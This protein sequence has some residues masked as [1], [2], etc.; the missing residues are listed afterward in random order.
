[1]SS[2]KMFEID[3]TKLHQY[4]EVD[5]Y[6]CGNKGKFGLFIPKNS[7]MDLKSVNPQKKLYVNREDRI[8]LIKRWIRR[9][10]NNV[11]ISYDEDPKKAKGYLFKVA[12]HFFMDKDPSVVE[13]AKYFITA[14]A[15]MFEKYPDIMEK[16]SFISAKDYSIHYHNINVM[17]YCMDFATKNKRTREDVIVA[18]LTGFLHDIG[19]IDIDEAILMKKD[20]LTKEE[21]TLIQNHPRFGI[22]I[23][24][25]CKIDSRIIDVV[26]EHHER[27]DGSGYPRGKFAE[28]LGMHSRLLAII[29][30]FDGLTS[31]R[32]YK[33]KVSVM[34]A[35]KTLREEADRGKY[36][37]MILKQFAKCF[38][39]TNL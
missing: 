5:I 39:G 23:L 29:D 30:S 31:E 16:L 8:T 36:D 38:I 26:W 11:K 37:S 14:L 27:L 20:P 22:R 25:E 12:S 24:K 6:F 32:P 35:F 15:T 3:T 33:K 9:D 13:E 17:L 21:L 34:S 2:E 19:K 1:M 7:N 28:S 4:T 18:G 10:V